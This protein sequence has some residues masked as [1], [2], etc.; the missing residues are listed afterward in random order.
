MKQTKPFCIS[1]HTVMAAWEKVR[2]NRGTYGIDEKSIADFEKDLK[3][4]L[5]KVW[6]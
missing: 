2:A 1:K 6:N 5:Y 4:N 3:D